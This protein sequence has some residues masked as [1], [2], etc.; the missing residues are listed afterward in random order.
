MRQGAGGPSALTVTVRMLGD[1]HV[2]S[3]AGRHGFVDRGV[4]R[5]DDGLPFVPAKTLVGVWRDACETAARALDGGGTEAAGWRDWVEFLFGGQPALRERDVTPGPGPGAGLP[6]RPAV[7]RVDGLHCP[8]AVAAA[9]RERPLLRAAAVFVKPGV[10]IDPE[11]G[12]AAD[13]LLRMEEMARG[14]MTLSGGA[15]L[16]FAGAELTGEQLACAG[17]LLDAGARLVEALGGRRRRGAGRCRLEVAGLPGAWRWLEGRSAPPVPAAAGGAVT[18]APH[19]QAHRRDDTA[20]AAEE[21][22]AGQEPEPG[23]GWEVAELRL[24]LRRPLVAHERTV[25]NTVRSAGRVPGW[26]LLP[27]VLQRLGSAGAGAAA[28]AGRLVVTDA[29]VEV[30]GRAGRPEPLALAQAKDEPGRLFN[31][32]E[33]RAGAGVAVEPVDGSGCV[34]PHRPG[35]PLRRVVC[36]FTQHT[37][38]TVDDALQRPVEEVGGLYTYQAIAARTEL[39]AQVRLPA[40]LVEPGWQ[41]RLSGTWRLGQSRK[42]GYGLCEVTATAVDRAGVARAAENGPA[43]EAAEAP[44]P[45]T[46]T[47]VDRATYTGQASASA[48]EPEAVKGPGGRLRVWLL[49]DALVV[50][51]RLRP[52]SRPS[53]LARVLGDALGVVLA[54][55]PQDGPGDGDGLV[56]VGVRFS[57]VRRNDPWHAR[58]GLPRA[59]LLG[60]RAGSCLTFE[61]VSGTVTAQAVARVECRG[62]G[63]RRAEG[64]GQLLVDDPLLYAVLGDDVEPSGPPAEPDGV[65]PPGDGADGE[66]PPDIAASLAVLEEAAW[67][68]ALHQRSPVVAAAGRDAVLGAGHRQVRPSQLAALLPLLTHLHGPADPAALAWLERLR[69]VPGERRRRAWPDDVVEAVTALLREPAR[70]WELL[71]L[72]EQELV[73]RPARAGELRGRLW[74]AAVRA[75]VEDCLTALRRAEPSPHTGGPLGA[76]SAAYQA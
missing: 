14:G 16:D 41:Q 22:G 27:A 15:E 3:G 51:E 63:L 6:P 65:T 37:H 40:G 44:G 73:T 58:W 48:Y 39:R 68:E 62:V 20:E 32:L 31:R 69:Q 57:E 4:Q 23:A 46:G 45:G 29:T 1:W 9:L 70:V 36:A 42:D 66:Q 71:D 24:V 25:G 17:A 26:V 74:L 55:V 60:L 5:D 28:R 13:D 76:E 61:V 7:L 12:R 59:S 54:E 30:A 72:P 10:V 2:G 38:N 47:A 35:E 18:G 75:L 11:T 64:F 53:D 19:V 43:A 8:P 52:S 56:G 50:D 21:P 33:E 67:R 49:S 34:G